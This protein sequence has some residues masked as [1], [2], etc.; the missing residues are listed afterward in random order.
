[1]TIA[2]TSKGADLTAPVDERFGRAEYF[3]LFDTETNRVE[4]IDNKPNLNIAQGAGVQAAQTVS[5]SGADFVLTG[6]CGPKAFRALDEAGISVCT[7][8]T[9]TVDETIHSFFEGSLKRISS[10]DKD[11]HWE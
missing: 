8:A 5:Q 9:G 2:V 11:G 3:V 7:G 4:G 1:M 10:A 6:H